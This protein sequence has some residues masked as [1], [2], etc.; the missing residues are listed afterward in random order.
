MSATDHLDR[1][2]AAFADDRPLVVLF[3]QDAWNSRT[4]INRVL[5]MAIKRLDL[6]SSLGEFPSFS[7]LLHGPGVPADFYDWMAEASFHQPNPPWLETVARLPLNAVFTSSVDPAIPRSFRTDGRD[8][9]LVLS[10][11]DNPVSP[12]SRRQ[13]H[14]T[15]LFGRAGESEPR[16]A[17]PRNRADLRRRTASHATT[18]LSRLVDTTT[19]LGTLLIDGLLCGRDWLDPNILAGILS[20]FRLGQVFWFGSPSDP[21]GPHDDLLTELSAP[22][23]PVTFVPERLSVALRSLEFAHKIDLSRPPVFLSEGSVRIADQV[24]EIRAADRLRVSTAASIIEDSWLA[25]L[26]PIGPDAE[27]TEFRRFHGQADETRRLLDGLRRG[28]SIE[29]TFE[30]NLRQETHRL[31]AKGGRER[32]PLLLHGQSGSGKSIALA[33]LAHHVRS[34]GKY[35]VLLGSRATR[36]PAVEELD[37]FCLKAEGAGA[38]ATL[39]ICDANAPASRYR[40]LLRGFMSRGRRVV[41]VGS[42]YRILDEDP[43]VTL[44]ADGA[45]LEVPIELDDAESRALAALVKTQTGQTVQIARSPYLLPALY[46]VLPEVRPRL[47]AG[48][49]REARVAEDGL[50][51]RGVRRGATPSKAAT[52]LGAALVSAGLVD[53]KSVLEQTIGEFLGAA[54]DAASR[55]IDTVMVP[56]KLDCPVPIGLLMRTVGGTESAV[57]IVSLFAGIDLFR[58]ISADDGDLLV[59]PR[60]RVEAELIA[61]RRLGTATAEAGV[62]LRLLGN[63]S[64]SDHDSGERRFVLN[65]VHKLGPDGPFGTRYS[66]H[67]LAIARAL[68]DMRVNRGVVDPSFMLQEAT[69]RRR[70]LRDSDK[71]LDD[72]AVAILEEAKSIVDLALD[73]LGSAVTRRRRRARTNLLVERAAIYGFRAVD[74]VRSGADLAEV[75]QFYEAARQS[76]RSAVFVADSYHAVD[77]SIWVPNDL[78]ARE[79]WGDE[80]RAELVA[81]IYDGLD[82]VDEAQL[83]PEQQERFAERR[84]RVAQT[85]DDNSLRA[86]ALQALEELGSQAGVFLRA[87]TIGGDLRGVAEATEEERSRSAKAAEFLKQRRERVAHDARCLRYYLKCLWMM[88]TGCYLFGGERLPLPEPEDALE[89]ILAVLDDLSNL[90]G[91]SGDARTEY[92]RAVVMWRLR[93]GHGAE[94]VWKLL[95]QETAFS[96]PRRVVRHHVWTHLAGQARLF[97]G[98]VVKSNV[99]RGRARVAVEEIR[100]DVELLQRDFPGVE[101][102]RGASIPGGFHIAFNF[103]GPVADPPARL[104]GGR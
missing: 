100:Q 66:R 70:V 37:D 58:W 94:E 10:T 36:V 27:Y 60:L 95:S 11:L 5:E 80:R 64:P 17:P 12:R 33:R 61:A 26:L 46:R 52:A 14:L 30:A 2:S 63:A 84:Y 82:R 45:L 54:S 68:S 88:A 16:E 23:G 67:Y 74:R 87:R 56:G 101:L 55:V 40:D 53:P 9:E 79:G 73:E 96:D 65:F 42:A 1:L 59:R 71:L 43:D 47:A 75:W 69:L 8:V 76:A 20:E 93:R 6:Q 97:H 41:V 29:R 3:G 38:E 81:D 72:D 98:R 62:A 44:D 51:E 24:L 15:Y 77:V 13:L 31:L 92:L 39:L 32:E 21:L 35:P 85:L 86:N 18:L 28:Y 48:L 103:I 91:A 7:S 99:D 49:A 104:G 89:D 22:H 25:P 102:R 34:D 78:L 50:R 4:S 83:A 57:D 90:E 19:P